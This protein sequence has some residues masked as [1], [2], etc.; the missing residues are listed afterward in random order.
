MT[1]NTIFKM[2]LAYIGFHVRKPFNYLPF[3]HYFQIDFSQILSETG[4]FAR[5][6]L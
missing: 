4:S 6:T 2:L 3:K 5:C 1:K